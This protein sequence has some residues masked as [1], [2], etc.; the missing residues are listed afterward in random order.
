[1]DVY[2]ENGDHEDRHECKFFVSTTVLNKPKRKARPKKKRPRPE[3]SKKV[4]TETKYADLPEDPSERKSKKS[5]SKKK[6]KGIGHVISTL[7]LILVLGVFA[8]VMFGVTTTYA[9]GSKVA[10]V[11]D[12]IYKNDYTGYGYQIVETNV[13]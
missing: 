4:S 7:I 3:E 2:D 10:D 11:H 9:A 5:K 8:F 6:K 12:F 13:I 1:M